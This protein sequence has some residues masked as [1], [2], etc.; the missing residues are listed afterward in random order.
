METPPA[1]KRAVWDGFQTARV[2]MP[3]PELD[4]RQGVSYA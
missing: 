1:S 4:D 3:P 2:L